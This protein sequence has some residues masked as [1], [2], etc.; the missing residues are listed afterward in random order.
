MLYDFDP[1]VEKFKTAKLMQQ[2]LY[3]LRNKLVP[4]WEAQETFREG[5]LVQV[6]A[7]LN[8]HHF[9]PFDANHQPYN[10]RFPFLG[11]CFSV[12]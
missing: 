4:P 10:M 12:Y 5:T 2:P 9:P 8:V 7:H 11:Y 3:D 1:E 6:K